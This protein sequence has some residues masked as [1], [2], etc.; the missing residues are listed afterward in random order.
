M[1]HIIEKVPPKLLI[2]QCCS[3]RYLMNST[4]S[5]CIMQNMSCLC[6]LLD[7]DRQETLESKDEME[8]EDSSDSLGSKVQSHSLYHQNYIHFNWIHTWFFEADFFRIGIVKSTFSLG[9]LSF[10]LRSAE[11]LNS[12][13]VHKTCLS[14]FLYIEW[15]DKTTVHL[16]SL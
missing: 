16:C 15:R 9:L 10:F 1:Y 2:P 5:K 3:N 7:K 12:N 6:M 4:F 11:E 13:F 8:S 14:L